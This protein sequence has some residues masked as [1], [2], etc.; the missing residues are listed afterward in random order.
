MGNWKVM[1]LKSIKQINKTH[2]ENKKISH[3]FVQKKKQ[4]QKTH[5]EPVLVALPTIHIVEFL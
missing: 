2:E 5:T 3:Y 1:V 4:Q